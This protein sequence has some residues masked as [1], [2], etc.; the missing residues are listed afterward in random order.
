MRKRKEEAMKQG[1]TLLKVVSII[2]IVFAGLAIIAGILFLA[3]GGIAATSGATTTGTLDINGT[4][5]TGAEAAIGS[6]IIVGM[7]GGLM[8]FSGIIDLVIGIVGVKASGENGKHTAAFV[9]GII[10]VI[11]AA[12]SLI[13]GV[14]NGANTIA[15]GLVGLVLPVL[16]L[17]GVMQTRKQLEEQPAAPQQF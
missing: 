5:Y 9:L 1:S 6:G 11:C 14:A 13:F 12:I 7:L 17:V 15:S 16:Y 3:G 2:M 8:L 4:T 10:G